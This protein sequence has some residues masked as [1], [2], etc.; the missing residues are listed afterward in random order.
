M[1]AAP[2]NKGE[3]RVIGPI[4]ARWSPRAFSS[5]PVEREKLLSVLEAAR[6]AASSFNEQP[7]RFIVATRSGPAA[8]EKVLGCFKESNRSWAAGAPVIMLVLAKKTFSNTGGTNRHALYDAGQAVAQLS[9]QAVALELYVH[10]MAGILPD[11]AREVF[12][13]PDDFEIVVGLALGYLSNVSQLPEDLQA[14][15]RRERKRKALSDL[16]FSGEFGQSAELVGARGGHQDPE[17]EVD[18]RPDAE[19]EQ[20]D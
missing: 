10:Q 14:K 20:R 4:A 2:R 17:H 6:W 11:K 12:K 18:E 15:E 3:H 1:A 9:L 16:V 5:R 19:R 13:I 8:F 7:W